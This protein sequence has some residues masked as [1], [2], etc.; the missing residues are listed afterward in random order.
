MNISVYTR[1]GPNKITPVSTQNQTD[2]MASWTKI[3]SSLHEYS[4]VMCWI[5]RIDGIF[6]NGEPVMVV[7]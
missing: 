7:W 2:L 5:F 6:S 3:V 4:V 1:S